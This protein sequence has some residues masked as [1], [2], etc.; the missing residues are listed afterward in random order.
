MF[1]LPG[2]SH[3]L[4]YDQGGMNADMARHLMQQ[5]LAHHHHAPA[6]HMDI[7]ETDKEFRIQVDL[8][9]HKKEDIDITV[10]DDILTIV[11]ERKEEETQDTQNWHVRERRLGKSS[12]SIRLPKSADT[13]SVRAQYVEGVLR[14][15]V[16][17]QANKTNNAKSIR[18]TEHDYRFAK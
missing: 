12:R 16:D 6:M 4:A 15:C 14:I 3:M 7:S 18:I 13:D 8:P 11:A 17:K 1:H 5:P 10:D 2:G 9:G